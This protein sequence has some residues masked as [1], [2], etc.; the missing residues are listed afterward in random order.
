[1]I[2]EELQREPGSRRTQVLGHAGIATSSWYRVPR[3]ESK[4]PGPQPHSYS[5]LEAIHG[6][7]RAREEAE[8]LCGPLQQE[9]HLVTDNGSSFIAKRFQSYLEGSFRQV[10]I[11]YRTPQ[12]LGLLER[13]HQTL[14][15]EE[16]YWRLYESPQH[17]RE[18]LAEFRARYNQVR[19]HWALVPAEGGDPYVPHEVYV[20]QRAIG[21]PRWQAW[22]VAAKAKLQD[23]I[24]AA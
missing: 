7:A 6:L 3:A 8:R 5:A 9:P 24:E 14:K 10:R 1:M 20:D 12:Q 23:Q 4:R 22:A 2:D 17:A 21:I 13:F 11:Q 19:P 15:S 18:C 16:V